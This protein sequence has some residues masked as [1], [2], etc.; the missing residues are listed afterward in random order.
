MKNILRIYPWKPYKDSFT[1]KQRLQFELAGVLGGLIN[2]IVMWFGY[3]SSFQV[4][5]QS[6]IMR[7]AY[8]WDDK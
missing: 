7:K 1:R 3:Y 2:L 5:H 8:K 4:A 6:K